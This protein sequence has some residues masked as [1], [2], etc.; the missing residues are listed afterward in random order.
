MKTTLLTI[1]CTTAIT[2]ASYA[3]TQL[4]GT[5][6]SG[7]KYGA[8]TIFK[9]DS[10]G[11]N[12]TVEHDFY[13]TPGINPIF[14]K[15]V[16][17]PNG[18]LYGM[19]YEGGTYNAGVLFE[20]DPITAIYTAK[21]NFNA[22]VSPN[23]GG[24]PEGQLLLASDGNLYGTTD[25]GGLNNSGILFQYNYVTDTLI[26]KFNFEGTTSGQYA[27][28]TLMQANNGLLYG[29]CSY[30]G[31]N[32]AGT[33]FSYN[34]TTD[35]LI[36]KANFTGANGKEA[37]G[38]LLQAAD[39]NLYGQAYSGGINNNGALY[40]YNIALDTLIRKVSF[41]NAT[42]GGR[43][44]SGLM[45]AYN[46]KLYAT[47]TIGGTGFNGTL[48]EYDYVAD[49][50]IVKVN[51][52]YPIIGSQSYS[53]L[54]QLND[55]TLYGTT[56]SGG[57][58]GYG[59]IFQ[60]SP[61]TDTVIVKFNFNTANGGAGETDGS[62]MLATDGN[63]YG[64]SYSGGTANKGS[65]YQYNL[66]TDTAIV[67][68]SFGD[69]TIGANPEAGLLKASN[70]KLY[71]TTTKGGIYN[72][73]VLFE[74]DMATKTHTKKFDFNNSAVGS[75]PQG[76]LMQASSGL[77]YG[78]TS[79]GGV[80]GYGTLFTYN[81][82]TDTLI[83]KASF[84]Y[85]NGSE[86]KGS[87]IE[88]SNGML[89]GTTRSGGVYGYGVLYKY[90]PITDTLIVTHNF[91][92]NGIEGAFPSATVLQAFNGKIYGTTE[93]GN[94][95][96]GAIFEYDITTDS[97]VVVKT[98]TVATGV[99]PLKGLIQGKDSLLYGVTIGGGANGQGT[100]YAYNLVD[101]TLT[102]KIDL[103]STTGTNLTT[104]LQAND[105]N[106][107]GLAQNQGANNSGA[108]FQYNLANSATN[109]QLY[110]DGTLQGAN[111]AGE[112][113]EVGNTLT[114]AAV[115][116]LNCGSSAIIVPYTAQAAFNAN[117]VFTVQ[118]SD[119][120]GSFATPTVVGTLASSIASP[121]TVTLPNTAGT[122][123]LIRVVSSSPAL[124]GASNGVNITIN[125]SGT[126]TQTLNLCAGQSTTVGTNTYTTSGTYVDVF[127]TTTGCDS[128][129]TTNLTVNP[130][131]NNTTVTGDS[132]TATVAGATYQW[133]DCSTNT[134]LLNDTNQSYV[135]TA[136]GSYA[137]VVTLNGCTDTSACVS[138]IITN[139]KVINT[140]AVISAYPNPNNGTFS[141]TTA[142]YGTYTIANEL[143]QVV[144]TFTTNANAT[145]AHIAGLA[146][147]IYVIKNTE[148]GTIARTKIVVTQ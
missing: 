125:A 106:I 116:T 41:K 57:A 23:N 117:N 102:V 111:P 22:A 107:Y 20:Y 44:T 51:F 10:A 124:I 42:T 12:H 129:I 123:Y 19:A 140:P 126:S 119:A 108:L 134:A 17:A 84:N 59:T 47:T 142:T 49:T 46:G 137:V 122:G 146:S 45:Q 121:I 147:G 28:A 103:N 144:S 80:N 87:P 136:T 11:A 132:I 18:K 39:G 109:I 7:G 33:L 14:G 8:G 141:I 58:A 32:N 60:Y 3:Q 77:L 55:S 13:K 61:N 65:L 86:A 24:Y 37:F 104:L 131:L 73:G 128:T 105:G 92:E 115:N 148:N 79:T 64:F 38:E 145:T 99:Q 78:T 29:V 95:N 52:T 118:L 54:L 110:F 62:L 135:A 6:N 68:V 138:I 1:A 21:H 36:V 98:F 133:I 97:L 66:S 48:Y 90:S 35:T 4:W 113:I 40:C 94:F 76:S 30:G 82:I 34:I 88:A 31:L 101:N 143:G 5:T 83:V 53:T 96:D 130:V 71:G 9:T 139:T 127:T 69:V 75:S 56:Y 89:Y 72:G 70:G 26:N 114:T 25:N 50:L 81:L 85:S 67:K 120:A 112:L 100:M 16:Q 93:Y 2:L 27:I 15:M 63:L 43:P 91:D 74:Y